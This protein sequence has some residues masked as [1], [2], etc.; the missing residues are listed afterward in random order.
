MMELKYMNQMKVII[1]VSLAAMFSTACT[2]DI[3]MEATGAN[4]VARVLGAVETAK[5]VG[6]KVNQVEAAVDKY[7]R[8]KQTVQRVKNADYTIK[9]NSI[10]VTP[11]VSSAETTVDEVE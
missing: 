11:V 5:E 3:F 2:K 6:H 7:D 1:I 10:K 9:H 4:S 8:A